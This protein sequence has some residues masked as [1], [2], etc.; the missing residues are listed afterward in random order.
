[1]SLDLAPAIRTALIG[2]PTISGLLSEFRGEPAVFT[3]RPTP[4]GATVP[5]IVVS[6]DIALGDVD[7]LI[8]RRPVVMRDIIVYGHN[9]SDY[10]V[11]ESMGY[12]IRELFHRERDS[13][14]LS[15]HYII[16]ITASGPRKAPSDDSEFVGRVISLTIRL[17]ELP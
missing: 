15:T 16:D 5:M 17:G 1:M 3:R 4:S 10:R 14:I 13:L 8:S 6:E 7:A 12:A 2:E 11:V 9:D